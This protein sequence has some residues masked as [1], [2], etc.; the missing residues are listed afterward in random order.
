MKMGHALFWG[1]LLIILGLS[2]II[3]IVFNVNFPLFKIIIAF[4]FIFIGIK[5]LFGGNG[6]FKFG[7]KNDILFQERKY[8]SFQ[9]AS[10]YNVFFGK[11]VFDFRDINLSETE[12]RIKIVT[13]FGASEIKLDKNTPVRIKADVAFAGLTFPN[14]N[15][16]ILGNSSYESPGLD[17]QEA[18]LDIKLEAVFSAVEIKLY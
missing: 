17:L 4:L 12:K 5:I 14:G 9:D 15:S 8:S 16:A 2:I 11:G 7:K 13:V 1:L 10:D 6:I 3:R 18:F